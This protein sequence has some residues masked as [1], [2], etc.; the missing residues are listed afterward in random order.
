[1]R[2]ESAKHI[3]LIL[4]CLVSIS[5]YSTKPSETSNSIDKPAKTEFFLPVGLSA[6]ER[7]ERGA[8]V[9]V[10]PLSEQGHGTGI[11][12]HMF[13]KTV[14]VTAKHVTEGQSFLV[15][16]TPSGEKVI[17]Q[18]AFED[19]TLDFSVIFVQNL[20]TRT[21]IE[22]NPSLVSPERLIGSKVSYSGF[23]GAHEL[24]TARGY[25][26]SIERGHFVI[27]IF[28]WF[29]SSGSS[30]FDIYGRFVGIVVGIDIGQPMQIPIEDVVWVLP[31]Q[32]INQVALKQAIRRQF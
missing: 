17:G 4:L 6:I 10:M 13:G 1:M 18:L 16:V 14:V 25:I 19:P 11:Y 27:N 12:M 2:K 32:A 8:A 21:A 24:F 26:S 31:I 20:K 9:K 30:V 15:I 7:S 22:Y 23:P 3:I 28:G 5:C 29:G